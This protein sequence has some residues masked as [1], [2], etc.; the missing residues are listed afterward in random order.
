MPRDYE[1]LHDIGDMGD[2]EL[3]DLIGQ[4]LGEYPDIDVDDLD[5]HVQDGFVTLSGHV[6]TEQEVQVVAQVLTDVLGVQHYSNEI[7]I[8]EARR[9]AMP[10]AADEEVASDITATPQLGGAAEQ[11][12]DTSGHLLEHLEEEL[13]STHDLGKAIQEGLDYEA[14]DRPLQEGSW[15]EENH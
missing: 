15:S 10:E 13:Y 3:E 6:G 2:Q 8:D 11:A 7:V 5:I 14:P 12:S 1:D 9:A 4:E